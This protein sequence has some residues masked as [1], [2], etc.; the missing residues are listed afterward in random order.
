MLAIFRIV[1]RHYGLVERQI[2]SA[3]PLDVTHKDPPVV[4][5]PISCWDRLVAKS[6][7][8]GMLLSGDIIAVHLSN[9]EGD[10]AENEASKIRQ[11]WADQVEAPARSAG[12][13]PPKL[14]LVRTPYREFITPLLAHIE[15]IKARY[16]GR[17]IAVIIPEIVEKHWWFALLHSNRAY[18]LRSALRARQNPHVIVIDLPWFIK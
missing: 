8:F 18:R 10:A 7:Q 12:V 13:P 15:K 11:Q 14:E 9:L 16:P 1:H 2:A 17:P 3:E 4:L 6:L 5:V